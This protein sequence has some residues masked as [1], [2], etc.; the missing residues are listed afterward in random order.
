MREHAL[1]VQEAPQHAIGVTPGPAG[2]C[3]DPILARIAQLVARAVIV[4]AEAAARPGGGGEGEGPEVAARTE[5]IESRGGDA[6][7][8]LLGGSIAI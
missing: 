3:G 5:R 2:D 4:E 6:L 8:Q 7:R 1:E